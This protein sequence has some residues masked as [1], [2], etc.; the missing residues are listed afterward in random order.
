MAESESFRKS[1]KPDLTFEVDCLNIGIVFQDDGLH[2]AY[3]FSYEV[4]NLSGDPVP[5]WIHTIPEITTKIADIKA[6]D[7]EGGLQFDLVPSNSGKSSD[8]RVKFRQP[9]PQGK[10]YSFQF[11]FEYATKSLI[12]QDFFSRMVHV[13]D[14]AVFDVKCKRLLY[15]INAPKNAKIL[16]AIPVAEHHD[17]TIRYDVNN[18]Q[19]LEMFRYLL[20][21][22]QNRVTTKFWKWLGITIVTSIIS[23]YIA[24]LI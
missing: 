2:A 7:A 10:S 11:S 18:V 3:T 20:A 16:K 17:N 9:L 23:A 6:S 15:E 21:Y 13:A 19:P 5:E 14:F 4:S 12:S 8:L 1:V 24:K 22:R